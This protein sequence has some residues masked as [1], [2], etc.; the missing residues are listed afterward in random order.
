MPLAYR[1]AAVKADKQPQ[2]MQTPG[3]LHSSAADEWR[4]SVQKFMDRLLHLL[5]H[6]TPPPTHMAVVVDAPGATF[7]WAVTDPSCLYVCTS[8]VPVTGPRIIMH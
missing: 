2:D 1:C 4:S 7:R 3:Q 8:L 5:L 6:Q